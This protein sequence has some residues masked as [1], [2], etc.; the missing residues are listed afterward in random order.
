MPDQYIRDYGKR[1]YGLCIF[2][3]A[4]SCE[5]DD[6]YQETWLKVVKNFSKYDSSKDFEPWLTTIC[7]NTYRNTLRRIAR[8]PLFNTFS[9]TEEK[10][11]LLHSVPAPEGKDYSALY[12]AIDQLPE[13]LR[14]TVI[15][16]YFRDMDTEAVASVLGIPPG[17]V[18]SRLNK[19]RNLLKEVLTD[20]TDLQ[21]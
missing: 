20:E 21:F 16:F 7:V 11:E 10:E 15:L 13:K 3:C 8:S 18:K 4:N 6:L 2:L 19:A 5:A 12:S 17:T 1:L 9:T 14:L